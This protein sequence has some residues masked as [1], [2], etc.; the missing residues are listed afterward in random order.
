M[1]CV[2]CGKQIPDDAKFCTA[3]SQAVIIAPEPKTDSGSQ[4]PTVPQYT[5]EPGPKKK[6]SRKK[7]FIIGTIFA[8]CVIAIGAFIASKML[9]VTVY[10]VSEITIENEG[11][12]EVEYDNKGLYLGW[13][14]LCFFHVHE[15]RIT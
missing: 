1:F 10:Q 4:Q 15:K 13:T 14:R 11:H 5:S 7:F 3:C 12:M 2:K 6:K 9:F 8:V